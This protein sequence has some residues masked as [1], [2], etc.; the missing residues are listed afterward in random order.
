[1]RFYDSLT[2]GEAAGTDPLPSAPAV[3]F[4]GN[5]VSTLECITPRVWKAQPGTGETRSLLLEQVRCAW[6]PL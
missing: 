1:M 2:R 6:H 4:G 3:S 5:R